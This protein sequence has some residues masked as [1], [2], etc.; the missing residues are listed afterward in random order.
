M[1]GVCVGSERAPK[2]G[3]APKPLR[4]LHTLPRTHPPTNQRPP[5]PPPILPPT[6][7]THPPTTTPT[8]PP[9]YDEEGAPDLASVKPLIDGGTEGFKG[10][11]RVLIPGVT[12]CFEC[13]LW[14]FPPQTKFP[15]CTIAET[16]R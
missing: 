14:L 3:H 10:H 9:E 2:P 16:P 6:Y 15:L 13:T 5:P 8:H 12:P 1:R 11:A 4:P 7:H